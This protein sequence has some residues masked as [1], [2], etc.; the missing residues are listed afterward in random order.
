MSRKM[1]KW[2]PFVSLKEQTIYLNRLKQE[3][4]KVERP[5]L[6][7]DEMSSINETLVNYDGRPLLITYYDRGYI[8][9]LRTCIKKIDATN[10]KVVTTDLTIN[11]DDLIRLED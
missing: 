11:F 6:S 1:V 3:R 9:D 5:L 4:L 2:A 10:R 8:K 7:E